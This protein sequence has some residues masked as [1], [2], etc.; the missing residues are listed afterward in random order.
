ML[1][2]QTFNSSDLSNPTG[3]VHERV[4]LGTRTKWG[5]LRKGRKLWDKRMARGTFQEWDKKTYP[6]DPR[7]IREIIIK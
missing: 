4:E 7:V 2:Y 5:A 1:E 6:R 3:V